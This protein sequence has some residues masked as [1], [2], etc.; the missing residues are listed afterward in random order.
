VGYHSLFDDAI[1]HYQI[2]S[3]NLKKVSELFPCFSVSEDQR[4][5]NVKDKNFCQEAIE[6]LKVV[7]DAEIAGLEIL[8]RIVGGL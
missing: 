4:V 6:C 2:A 8:G 7:R 1:G 5:A 3:E